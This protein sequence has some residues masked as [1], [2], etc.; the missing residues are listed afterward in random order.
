LTLEVE[1]DS[2]HALFNSY[3]DIMTGIISESIFNDVSI[4]DIGVVI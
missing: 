4:F 2:G 1:D 3:D